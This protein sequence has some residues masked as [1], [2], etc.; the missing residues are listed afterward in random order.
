MMLT[1]YILS[2]ESILENWMYII[3]EKIII[4]SVIKRNVELRNEVSYEM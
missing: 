4:I 1:K 3:T 2:N